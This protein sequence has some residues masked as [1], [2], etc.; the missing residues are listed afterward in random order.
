MADKTDR[1]K[2]FSILSSKILSAINLLLTLF[3]FIIIFKNK[4]Y[5]MM[6]SLSI[7]LGIGVTFNAVSYFLPDENDLVCSTKSIIHFCSLILLIHVFLIYYLITLLM[8]FK[9]NKLKTPSFQFFIYILNW[10]IIV[11]FAILV[12]TLYTEPDE[13]GACRPDIKDG[14]LIIGSVYM[15]VVLMSTCIL[16]IIMRIKIS[17]LMNELLDPQ[18]SMKIKKAMKLFVFVEIV[19]LFNI[20]NYLLKLRFESKIIKVIDR[21]WEII[22]MSLA[23]VFI[24]MGTNNIKDF[25]C[26]DKE[27]SDKNYTLQDFK[28]DLYATDTEDDN[29]N[30]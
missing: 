17:K 28:D 15:M 20:L 10:I 23:V 26:K 27:E 7:H 21:L 29:K 18:I 14:K 16:Y 8:S 12:S 4:N 3:M 2:L 1:A 13:L 6:T 9:W 19:C 25:L 30:D 22:S 11:C 24:G 5:S